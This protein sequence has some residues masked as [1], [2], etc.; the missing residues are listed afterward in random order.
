M[1]LLFN[2]LRPRKNG[3]HHFVDNIFKLTLWSNGNLFHIT[4]PFWVNP[5][6][7]YG[8]PSQKPV[9]QCFD[10][11]FDLCVNKWS[12][13][14]SKHWWFETPSNSLWG[15]WNAFLH[16][17]CYILIQ[18]SLKL[19]PRGLINNNSGLVGTMAWCCR[20]KIYDDIFKWKHLHSTSPFCREFTCQWWIPSTKA[21]DV[22]LWCFLWY[23]PE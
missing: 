2:L 20:V 1:R 11:F 19:A 6:V 14:Q 8:F 22:E 4:G 9:M 17:N 16:T 18:I 7:I 12:S 5:L 15:H 3:H 13:K 23:L 21:S 10:V